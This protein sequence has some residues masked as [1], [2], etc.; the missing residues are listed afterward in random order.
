M[1][2]KNSSLK[3]RLFFVALFFTMLGFPSYAQTIAISGVVK[4]ASTGEFVI[5]ANVVEEGTTNGTI[6]NFDGEFSLNVKADANLIVKFVGYKDAVIAVAG[7]HSFVVEL[8]EDAVM[9]TEVVAI[10]YGSQTKKELTGAVASVKSESFNK[11]IQSSATGLLQGKVAGLNIVKLG[12]GDPTNKDYNVQLRGVG[13]LKG[14][15]SPLFIIDGVPGGDINS[16][17]PND[18]ESIDVL[19]DGSA[20][21]IYGTRANAGVI[22]VT[23]KRGTQGKAQIEYSG[24]LSADAISKKLRVL[25]AAEYRELMIPKGRADEGANTDW[26]KEIT[27]P[28]AFSQQHNVAMSGG[29]ENFTFRGSVGYKSN[30]GLAIESAYNEILTRFSANQKGLNGRLD[31]AY[32]FSYSKHEKSWVDYEA[33]NQ[34]LKNNPTRG[35][36]Y[37]D[38]VGQDPSHADFERYTMYGGYV[39]P[40]GFS[41]YNPV[42]IITGIDDDGKGDSFLGSVRASFNINDNFKIG[43]FVS[44]QSGNTWT[45]KYWHKTTRYGEGEKRKGIASHSY[46]GYANKLIENTLQYVNQFGMH[47]VSGLLGQSYQYNEWIGFNGTNTDFITNLYSYHNMGAGM[48]LKKNDDRVGLGSYKDSDKLASFFARVMYNYNQ[49][50]FLNASVRMEGSSRFGPKADPVLGRYGLFPALSGSWR[51]KDED[52]MSSV[53]FIYDMKIRAGVG[54]TGNMP[55]DTNLYIQRVG[56]TGDY[57]F[58]DGEYVQPWGIASNINEFLKWEKKTEYNLGIDADFFKDKLSVVLDGYYRNTTNLLW[59]YNVPMPPYPYGKMWDNY[60]QIQNYGVELTLNSHIYQQKDLDI[61]GGLILAWN[62]NMVTRISSGYEG[63]SDNKPILD[64]GYI[65]GDGETGVNVMRL[66]EGEPIGNFYGF[67]FLRVDEAGKQVFVRLNSKGEVVGETT[68]PSETRDK[69]II[70]NAQPLL[71]YGFNFNVSYKQ[72]DLGT[73]FRGQIGGTIFNMKRYFYENINSAENVLW[74][75]FEGEMGKLA[76]TETR[77][78]SDYFLEDASY[79]RL[80]DVTLGYKIATTKEVAKYISDIRLSLTVQNAFVITGYKGVDPEVNQGGLDPGIDGLNY[81]PKQRS[82]L[83]GLN[84]KF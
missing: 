3:I 52:F 21:A 9:L 56:P 27:R 20:A 32:D 81:Y 72:F 67:K 43:S 70:G 18:I 7:R 14:S 42:P 51:I 25:N 61:H 26:L 53:D 71:T 36:R 4:E 46:G 28:L 45:G 55:H 74:S 40:D 5:G 37:D 44:Y 84:F 30:Q 63:T 83:F 77:R 22:L 33:F 35:V 38:A 10:G 80:N 59:E 65:S 79:L 6:T 69:M 17:N 34:A 2:Y 54:V 39:E 41:T 57:V 48:G 23:T 19:K 58:L 75:A 15:Q 62:R 66:Q 24:N 50:Y 47:A 82:F 49:R 68:S 60:G 11:G 16:V 12:G 8:Q 13:S 1:E 78:F 29:T 64:V 73:N 31:L 76:S